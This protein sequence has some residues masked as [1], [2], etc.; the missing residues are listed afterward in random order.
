MLIIFGCV[1]MAYPLFLL[2]C[3]IL[4]SFFVGTAFKFDLWLI[5]L[6]FVF[7]LGLS[8]LIFGIKFLKIRNN[9]LLIHAI[10]SSILLIWFI[11]FSVKTNMYQPQEKLIWCTFADIFSNIY[12]FK[13]V[14]GLYLAILIP[15]FFIGSNLYKGERKRSE[16]QKNG[17]I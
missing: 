17:L 15:Q 9:K 12:S 3:L 8:F 16:E 14:I 13:E 1:I 6:P 2:F 5:N 10:L 7:I 4:F 11:F